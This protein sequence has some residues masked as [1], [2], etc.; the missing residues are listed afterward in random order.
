MRA[1][2]RIA[3]FVS[4]KSSRSWCRNRPGL[5]EAE[6]NYL[7]RYEWAHCADDVLWRRTKLGLH[8]DAGERARVEAW[9]LTHWCDDNAT[10]ATATTERARTTMSG[11]PMKLQ[12]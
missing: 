7:R 11:E 9:C 8:M 3:Y 6:L 2:L 4:A 1:L 10:L 12:A 5:F